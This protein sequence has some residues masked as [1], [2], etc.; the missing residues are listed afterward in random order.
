MLQQSLR[1]MCSYDSWN[2]VSLH[3]KHYIF[4][5]W[6]M[7]RHLFLC[8]LVQQQLTCYILYIFGLLYSLH[9]LRKYGLS[10]QLFQ[11]N[12]IHNYKLISL[13]QLLYK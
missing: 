7:Y 3:H 4:Y 11:Y 8:V 2:L 12:N 6:R 10:L 9:L 1:L 13:Y 5:E